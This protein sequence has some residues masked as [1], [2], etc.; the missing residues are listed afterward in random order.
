[1]LLL[2]L[3]WTYATNWTPSGPLTLNKL[4]DA[5]ADGDTISLL[6][7]SLAAD[8]SYTLTANFSIGSKTIYFSTAEGESGLAYIDGNGNSFSV[9]DGSIYIDAI[10]AA[11][12]KYFIQPSGNSSVISITNCEISEIDRGVVVFGSYTIDTLI[13]DDCIIYHAGGGDSNPVL[14]TSGTSGSA[15][16][17]QLTN[18]T[19]SAVKAPIFRLTHR[20]NSP[21]EITVDHCTMDSIYGG[22]SSPFYAAT[23]GTVNDTTEVKF[24]NN[25]ISNVIGCSSLWDRITVGIPENQMV[26][27]TS[28]YGVGSAFDSAAS[29]TVTLASTYLNADPEYT[30]YSIDIDSRDYGINNS[31]VIGIES[32]DLGVIGDQRWTSA[33]SIWIP[34]NSDELSSALSSYQDGDTIFLLSPSAMD[35]EDYY[36][37]STSYDIKKSITI[38]AYDSGDDLP[39]LNLNE[40]YFTLKSGC[41]KVAINNVEVDSGA[42]LFRVSSSIENIEIT[43]CEISNISRNVVGITSS[44][45]GVDTLIVDNCI[46]YECGGG[47]DSYSVFGGNQTRAYYGYMSLTNSTLANI[48]GTVLRNT[49]KTDDAS[50]IIIDHCTFDSLYASNSSSPFYAIGNSVNAGSKVSI[51]NCLFTNIY[52]YSTLWSRLTIANQAVQTIDTSSYWMVDG[53]TDSA[54]SDVV[55]LSTTTYINSDPEYLHY[56]TDITTRDYTIFNSTVLALGTDGDRIGD[57]RWVTEKS[58]DA[59]LSDLMVDGTTVTGFAPAT[60]TYDIELAIGTTAIPVVSAT[61]NNAY[62]DT[63]VTQATALPG[64]AT[65]VVTS[66]NGAVTVTYT[67][68]FTIAKSDDATLSDLTV[69]G[70]TIDGFDAGTTTYDVELAAGTT[71]VPEVAATATDENATVDIVDATALPGYTNV[72][73]TAEDGDTKIVYTIN[74]T[75]G[76]TAVDDASSLSLNIYPNPVASDLIIE[77]ENV[78][79]E[80][81]IYSSNGQ[82][83][84][85]V[86][87]INSNKTQ[88]NV[89]DLNDGLYLINVLTIDNKVINSSFIKE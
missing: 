2:T 60:T 18:S 30:N 68:N 7:S 53:A 78:I 82:M 11:N 45:I 35:G 17:F 6:S 55:T 41:S 12:F 40:G 74:F 65:V 34:K 24:S 50:T 71:V 29:D 64:E 61:P 80:A 31:K 62:A 57:L 84:K 33:Y 72:T 51:T 73:V 5:I 47:S 81:Y 86:L 3:S 70:T 43:N 8:S 83:V 19:L 4:V 37:T 13:V 59:S 39:I 63:V 32:T 69:D 87:N 27:A 14:G 22:A 25:V 77:N 67:I 28:Y 46:V 79:S 56:T 58:I 44:S 20:L 21:V 15:N 75:V 42:Y 38:E 36:A 66:E 16:Y 26:E 49:H 88:I 52:D 48:S 76:T 10:E 9:Q 89:S 54:S 1:M 85:S 23:K